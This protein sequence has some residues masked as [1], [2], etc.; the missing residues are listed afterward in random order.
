MTVVLRTAAVLR[1]MIVQADT[2]PCTEADADVWR[3]VRECLDLCRHRAGAL[4]T[5]SCESGRRS[6]SAI[7]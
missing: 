5:R 3:L 2:V 7:R 4:D 1:M 6:R